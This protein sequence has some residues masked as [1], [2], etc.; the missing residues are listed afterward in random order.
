MK[1]K[2]LFYLVSVFIFNTSVISDDKIIVTSSDQ[3]PRYTYVLKKKPSQ[4]LQDQEAIN[5]LRNQVFIDLKNELNNY[6]IRD[7]STLR[8]H[9][10]LIS[11]LYMLK[12][13]YKFALNASFIAEN[14]AEKES[15]KLLTGL[16]LRSRIEAEKKISSD[17][18]FEDVFIS[19]YEKRIQSLKWN[20][21]EKDIK[22]LAG[23]L[24]ILSPQLILGQIQSSIDPIV[25]IKLEVSHEIARSLVSSSITLEY[26]LPLKKKI[27][28]ILNKFIEKNS[29][30]SRPE[31]WSSR[32]IEFTGK[33]PY[34]NILIAIWDSGVDV[35]VFEELVWTNQNEIL[36]GKDNDQ[37]G[38]IDDINGIAWDINS[39]PAPNLLHSIENLKSERQVVLEHTK[40]LMDLQASIG[41][42]EAEKLQIYISNLESDNVGSFLEDLSLFGNYIHGTHVAGISMKGNPFARVTPIRLTFDYKSIPS[43]CPTDELIEKSVRAF[44]ETVNY[45]KKIGVRVVNMSWGGSRADIESTLEKCKI[46]NSSKERADL[47]RK[48]FS[49]QKSAMEEAIRKASEIL[50]VT[51]AGNSNN[52]VSFDEMIPSGIKSPNLIV[53]GAVDH[54]G[55]PTSFT[56]FGSNVD[57]Y[58][59]GFEIESFIPGGSLLKASG[60]SMSSP[61]V[62]NLAGK[63]LTIA[64]NLS[65]KDIKKI[66]VDTSN[67]SYYDSN[68]LLVHPKRA[69]AK[70][71]SIKED[72]DAP[73]TI[74]EFSVEDQ[75]ILKKM[76]IGLN[77]IN[78][79]EILDALKSQL[80]MQAKQE[81]KRQKYLA[82]FTIEA[83]NDRLLKIQNSE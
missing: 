65:P 32:G 6:D 66:I 37:N 39:D 38:F 41:S 75:Q 46:G 81:D 13:D 28:N 12:K 36:D 78:D 18:N 9:N 1:N 68:I 22:S 79:K 29:N 10:I 44:A 48:Y 49:K 27:L 45:F 52:D 55:S 26:V 80:E 53:V 51:S 2:L 77:N 31:I 14:L 83:I 35:N 25:D 33:E 59:N 34:Q 73:K 60:T 71:N 19:E 15:E 24:R 4:V 43:V 56:S 3:L 11:Q 69:I 63:I 64:P 72:Q 61:Q 17:L 8:S 67:R 74:D 16:L 62:T 23:R 20:V 58:A 70:V 76:I 57:V 30:E 42:K 40:G 7:K 82:L 5:F 47:A 50:F 54:S 21:V